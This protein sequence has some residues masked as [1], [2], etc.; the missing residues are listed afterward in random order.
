MG[1]FDIK[2]LFLVII[3]A[4]SSSCSKNEDLANLVTNKS[5]ILEYA[6]PLGSVNFNE[7]SLIKL[8]LS[9]LKV[10][11][12]TAKPLI[13]TTRIFTLIS[14]PSAEYIKATKLVDISKLIPGSFYH[15]IG[16]EDFY[17]SL[18]TRFDE[19]LS[20]QKL[21]GSA[22]TYGWNCH[23]NRPPFVEKEHPDIL[24]NPDFRG[25]FLI[26]LSKP[27]T[28]FGFELA[29]NIKNK[30]TN[31]IGFYGNGNWDYS[32]GKISALTTFSP[33]GARLFAIKS[34]RPFT[35]VTLHWG[36]YANAE[37]YTPGG[38]AIANI[39]YTLAE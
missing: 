10:P 32:S 19:E 29:P 27:C 30:N 33:S 2:S 16:T 31:F 14:V 11:K 36:E 38:S 1:K 26:V 7:T 6:V 20:F 24:F 15:Q 25:E 21:K 18:F 34:T 12:L 37:N 22:S 4:L 23:W 17:L 9:P 35:T 13:G 39:R 8:G 3:T 28:E 5:T